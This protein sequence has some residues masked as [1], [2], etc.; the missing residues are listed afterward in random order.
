M[1][2]RRVV[3]GVGNEFRRDDGFGPRVV[4]EL[5]DRRRDDPR[6]AGV[7]LHICDGEP[8]RMLDAW[9]GADVAVVVDV[10]R[11]GRPGRW[12]E[13]AV[14]AAA[15]QPASGHGVGLGVTVGLGRV[16]GRMPAKLVALVGYGREFGFGVGLSAPVSSAIRP[17]ADRICALVALR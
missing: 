5:T 14:P 11:G 16:L 8:S 3:I 6:L 9:T 2:G 12:C 13:V 7:D 1:S 4:A 17:V 10:A 15:E